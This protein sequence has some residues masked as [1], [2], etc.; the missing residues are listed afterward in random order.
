MDAAMLDGLVDYVGFIVSESA[1]GPRFL[2]LREASS[3]A[4][5]LGRSRRVL[6]VFDMGVEEAVEAASRG[7]E[8]E[9]LQ[10]HRPASLAALQLLEEQLRY[11][12]VELAP[13]SL[14]DGS[15]L[16]PHPCS[17]SS[18]RSEYVLVDAAKGL[19]ARYEGGL[20][21]PLRAYRE[22]AG[23]LGNAAAAGGV[24]QG[25][26]CIVASTGVSMVDVSSG[27]EEAPGVKSKVRVAE[28]LAAA[29]F[30]GGR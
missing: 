25:N 14:W 9:V 17:L 21:A 2:S 29:R 1:V 8:F 24:N 12:G 16:T 28:L 23:C 30:C 22:A 11:M 4:S 18:I 15:S 10:Y 13:V 3:I 26:V 20:R 7:E 27:V 6:V 19:R 5:T